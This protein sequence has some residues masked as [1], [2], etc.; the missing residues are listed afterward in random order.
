MKLVD[1]PS[2]RPLIPKRRLTQADLIALAL[3]HLEESGDLDEGVAWDW[4]DGELVIFQ[5]AA[6]A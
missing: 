4:S 5:P 2:P 1:P 3:A 6:K